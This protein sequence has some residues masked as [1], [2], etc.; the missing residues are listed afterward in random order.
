MSFKPIGLEVVPTVMWDRRAGLTPV[1]SLVTVTEAA[2]R[3][4]VS[5]QAVLERINSGSLPAVRIGTGWA[6]AASA[7]GIGVDAATAF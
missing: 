5:R 1:P 6:I 3:L 2:Q 4:G 7:V